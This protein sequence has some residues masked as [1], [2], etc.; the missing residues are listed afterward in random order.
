MLL[1]YMTPV[2]GCFYAHTQ[3][4]VIINMGLWLLCF[5]IMTHSVFEGGGLRMKC[6]PGSRNIF[7]YKSLIP[8]LYITLF[9]LAR[10]QE[11]KHFWCHLSIQCA[12]CVIKDFCTH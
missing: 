8:A 4:K 5:C 6:K 9:K 12:L 1:K 2:S 3:Q 11:H 10:H 7:I